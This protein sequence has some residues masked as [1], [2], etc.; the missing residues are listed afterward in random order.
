M[1]NPKAKT[2]EELYSKAQFL[3]GFNEGF[4]GPSVDSTKANF[5][6]FCAML[7]SYADSVAEERVEKAF[8]ERGHAFQAAIQKCLAEKT[9]AFRAGQERMR[10]RAAPHK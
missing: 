2:A 9:E 4:G 10:E 3:H 6:E 8:E 5:K 7:E 1:S